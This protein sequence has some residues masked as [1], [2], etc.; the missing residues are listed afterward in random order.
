V[1]VTV[2]LDQQEIIK[3]VRFYLESNGAPVGGAKG[4]FPIDVYFKDEKVE[5]AL[6]IRMT[7][8]FDAE[9]F[10]EGPYR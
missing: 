9:H 1:K 10:T 8:T 2:Q 6:A 4:P 7:M 3:A 5:Q